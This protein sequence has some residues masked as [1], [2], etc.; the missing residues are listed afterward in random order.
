[1]N[2]EVYDFFRFLNPYVT[3]VMLLLK[4]TIIIPFNKKTLK[5]VNDGQGK[6]KSKKSLKNWLLIML[7]FHFICTYALNF[8]YI[9]HKSITCIL[10]FC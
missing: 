9:R 2:S 4:L 10:Y 1:M 6:T 5:K 3:V 8:K 7:Y